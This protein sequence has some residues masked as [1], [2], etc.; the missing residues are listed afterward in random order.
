[1]LTKRE[2]TQLV[3]LTVEWLDYLDI[4]KIEGCTEQDVIHGMETGGPKGAALEEKMNTLTRKEWRAVV[5]E[6]I[7]AVNKE[8]DYDEE[9]EEA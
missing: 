6:V 5:S 3:K 1:M 4:Y 9:L 7:E 2:K 8:L